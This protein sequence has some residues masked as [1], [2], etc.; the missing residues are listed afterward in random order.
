MLS[1][2]RWSEVVP[3]REGGVKSTINDVA[4]SPDGTRAIVAVGNRVLLYNAE[5]GEL[6]E[7]L[8]GHKDIVYCVDFSSDGSR[9]SSGGA[10][11]V[12]VIWKTTA[13]GGQGVLKYTHTAP[14]QRVKYNPTTVQLASCSDVDFGLWTPDQKQVVKEK[15]A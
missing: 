14:I 10:D 9:F 12:V 11:N 3:E 7:S 4:I 13:Q 2:S 8:R 5:T 1:R 15:V 6:I